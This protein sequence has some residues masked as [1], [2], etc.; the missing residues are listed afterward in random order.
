MREVLGLVSSPGLQSGLSAQLPRTQLGEPDPR[1]VVMDL[2]LA[3]A[4]ALGY[5]WLP[6]S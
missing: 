1:W 6:N 4:W 2:G 3:V 5:V